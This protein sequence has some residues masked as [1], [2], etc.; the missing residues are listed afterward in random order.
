MNISKLA[1]FIATI[2][3]LAACSDPRPPAEIV[4]DR[5]QARWDAMI[6]RDFE[7]AWQYYPPGYRDQTSASQFA[8]EFARRPVR[9]ENAEVDGIEC[10]Q[11]RCKT[12][13]RVDYSVP[14]APGQLAGMKSSREVRGVWIEIDGNWWYSPD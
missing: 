1:F 11:Q 2:A 4:A 10:E 7:K 6:E 8:A 5:A 9:W 3:L 13:A 14:G 12:T